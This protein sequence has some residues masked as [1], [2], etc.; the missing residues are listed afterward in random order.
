MYH[1]IDTLSCDPWELAVSTKNFEEQLGVLR[2]YRVISASQLVEE[3][4]NKKVSSKTVCL[5]FDDGYED[6]I[7][8]AKP[9]LEKYH[10]PATFFISNHFIHNRDAF[11]WDELGWLILESDSLPENLSLE[12]GGQS[13]YFYLGVDAELSMEKQ[14]LQSKWNW[15]RRPPTKRTE[16]YLEIWQLLK[17]MPHWQIRESLDVLYRWAGTKPVIRRGAMS[18]EQLITLV[19]HPLIGTGIHTMTHPSLSLHSRS[20]QQNEIG[21]SR[22]SLLNEGL[23][24][25]LIAYPYGDY[26]QDSLEIA[27]G[28]Q[29]SAGF[30]TAEKVITKDSNIHALGRFQVRN[31]NG[32]K[33]EKELRRWFAGFPVS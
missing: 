30:T 19:K 10:C 33:F 1:N 16:L 31:I 7:V 6:N 24:A 26:N 2:K 8:N 32:V 29:L 21:H 18:A 28:L 3:V 27:A 14:Q 22:Q 9:L 23:G 5:T 4:S 25:A 15:H 12:L 11:W 20:Y 17:P 13:I